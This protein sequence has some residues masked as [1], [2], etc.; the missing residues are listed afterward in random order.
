MLVGNLFLGSEA[1]VNKLWFVGC[2]RGFD[3]R[4]SILKQL[5]KHNHESDTRQKS[6]DVSDVHRGGRMRC[7]NAYLR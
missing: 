5:I 3:V 4:E 2:D 7:G 1:Q 6:R